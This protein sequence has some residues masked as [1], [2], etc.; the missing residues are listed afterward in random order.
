MSVQIHD[1]AI[2][3]F[4]RC[5]QMAE[6]TLFD[7]LHNEILALF[8]RD[9]SR[10]DANPSGAT[11]V[12]DTDKNAT[13]AASRLERV[14]FSTG[15]RLTER[16]TRDLPRFRDELD[17]VK[18]ICK[19]FWEAINRKKIDHLRANN[20][21]VYVLMDN[22]CRFLMPLCGGNASGGDAGAAQY[23]GVSGRYLAFACGLVRG[24]LAALGMQSVVTANISHIPACKFHVQMQR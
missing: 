17:M 9:S 14:G 1:Y 21:G 10:S 23:L 6:S 8:C 2:F 3:S 18:Y 5:H 24:A 11:T 22:Q 19:D 12:G 15:Y 13:D 7:F 16:M 4:R 20:Q